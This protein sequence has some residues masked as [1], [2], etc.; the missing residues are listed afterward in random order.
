MHAVVDTTRGLI[1]FR[2]QQREAPRTVENFIK[3]AKEGFYN[4]LKWHRSVPNFVIQTGCPRGD[5]TGGPGYTIE[6]ELNELKHSK[7]TVAMARGTTMNSGGSQFYIARQRL[8]HLDG[9]YTVFGQV[10]TG[11]D[12]IDKIQAGDTIKRITILED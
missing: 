10:T 4:G 12:V 9:Q 1:T 8:P 7:G 6:A 3:L 5:G 11:A 2:L